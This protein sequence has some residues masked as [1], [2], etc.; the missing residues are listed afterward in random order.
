MSNRFVLKH[1]AVR[2]C[3]THVGRV[4]VLDATSPKYRDTLKYLEVSNVRVVFSLYPGILN[5]CV[6][7]AYSSEE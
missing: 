2:D 4:L 1:D 5:L 6:A 7:S 3:G